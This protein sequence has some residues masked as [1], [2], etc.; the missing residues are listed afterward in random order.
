MTSDT[1]AIDLT[2]E[3][4]APSSSISQVSSQKR[5][6]VRAEH[7]WKHFR[8][9]ELNE[10]SHNDQNQRLHYCRLC[11]RKPYAT[12]VTT[13]AVGH[14]KGTH[15]IAVHHSEPKNRNARQESIE[16]AFQRQ[17]Q[18]LNASQFNQSAFR[19]AIVQLIANCNLPLSCI[20][21]PELQALLLVCNP[22]IEGHLLES[23]N[24][25]PPLL[26]SSFTCYRRTL[27][28]KLA[29]TKATIH[30]STDL[31][32]SPNRR[33]YLAIVAHWVDEWESQRALLALPRLHG[34]H[35]G[36]LQAEHVLETIEWYDIQCRLGYFTS[37][38][39]TSNDRLLRHLATSLEA[40]YDV[41]FDATTRRIRCTG[42]II[43][44]SL[45]AFL[46]AGNKEAL[47]LVNR[48]AEAADEVNIAE[49][50]ESAMAHQPTRRGKVPE[51]SVEDGWR[52]IG[53][54]GAILGRISR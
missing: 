16:I 43:N 25:I 10:P 39:A 13:N 47:N 20:E 34:S 29:A 33:A 15:G 1:S 44:L 37:D 7:I 26:E 2:S 27:K 12:G 41:E 48:L 54:L 35:G 18:L 5:R 50:L 31:W 14:L 40:R 9:P 19:E 17:A 3:S 53:P 22:S 52:S 23:R 45:Q 36:E 24:T 4:P 6:K 49:E 30:I 8:E 51:R 21:W 11:V 46:F 38:N 32:T 42:H 28:Q